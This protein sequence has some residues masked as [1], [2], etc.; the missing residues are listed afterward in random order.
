MTQKDEKKLSHLKSLRK[1]HTD[2][3]AQIKVCF[4]ERV[5]DLMILGM[6]QEKLRLKEEIVKIEEEL[7]LEE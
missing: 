6:K 4:D 7:Q 2:L 5:D 1:K 3:D